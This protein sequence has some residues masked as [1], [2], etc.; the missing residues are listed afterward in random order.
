[1][2]FTTA[3]PA[4]VLPLK[5][6]FPHWFSLTGLMAGAMAPDLIYFLALRTDFR[7]LSHSWPG[8]F[9]ITLP[10]GVVFSFVFHRYFKYS[11]IRH[12]PSPLDRFLSG[13][14]QSGWCVVGAKAWVILV[15]SVLVGSLSHFFWTLSLTPLV[16][17]PRIGRYFSRKLPCWDSRD[18]SAGYCSTPAP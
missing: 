6:W 12:L 5:Q 15:V 7:G 16:R 2:P 11:F 17:S 10:A 9:L 1:M 4:I 13:L 14:A 18:W 3:H 8:L